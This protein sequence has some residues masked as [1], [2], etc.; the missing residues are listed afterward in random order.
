LE[1]VFQIFSE[2][3][4]KNFGKCIP[5]FL[6]KGKIEIFGGKKESWGW[7]EKFS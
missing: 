3:E 2:F 1:R 7:E 6:F 4:L 5:E